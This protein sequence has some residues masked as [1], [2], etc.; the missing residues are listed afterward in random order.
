MKA[1]TVTTANKFELCT[2]MLNSMVSTCVNKQ[3]QHSIKT[4]LHVLMES[5]NSAH[6]TK[7]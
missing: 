2:L 4:F 7:L 3:V 1:I 6:H 5:Q